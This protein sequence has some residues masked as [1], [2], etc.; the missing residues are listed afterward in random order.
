[1]AGPAESTEHIQTI[2]ANEVC[3]LAAAQISLTESP[4]SGAHEVAIPLVLS[5]SE[6][7]RDPLCQVPGR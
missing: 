4:L 7:K 2:E 1:M 3:E 5:H 6:A